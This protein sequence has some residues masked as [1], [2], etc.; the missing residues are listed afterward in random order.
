MFRELLRLTAQAI[1][2][3]GSCS[4]QLQTT[5]ECT[6]LSVSFWS[7][8]VLNHFLLAEI[9]PSLMEAKKVLEV[10][11]CFLAIT[12]TPVS[13][14]SLLGFDAR[15]VKTLQTE[16]HQAPSP[17]AVPSFGYED[18]Y[19][20]LAGPAIKILDRYDLHSVLHFFRM[21]LR[22]ALDSAWMSNLPELR[23]VIYKDF[24]LLFNV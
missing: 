22:T 20:V 15:T 18:L 5:P 1:S 10:A 2:Q 16:L 4:L 9:T 13:I 8:N 12:S 24:T 6:K 7:G 21:K 11:G 19:K 14:Y 17:C 3:S 23:K